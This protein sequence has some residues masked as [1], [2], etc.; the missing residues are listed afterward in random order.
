M[1]KNKAEK[2]EGKKRRKG[3]EIEDSYGRVMASGKEEGEWGKG[4]RKDDR[5]R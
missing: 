4:R 3:G 1:K 5:K 2:N